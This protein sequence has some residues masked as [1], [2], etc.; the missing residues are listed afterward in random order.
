VETEFIFVIGVGVLLVGFAIVVIIKE[1]RSKSDY[2]PENSEIII[3]RVWRTHL[4]KYCNY[5]IIENQEFCVNCNRNKQ[6]KTS[7]KCLFC[8]KQTLSEYSYCQHCGNKQLNK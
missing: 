8:K 6:G 7:V 5:E 3:T 2:S 4:C 1:R